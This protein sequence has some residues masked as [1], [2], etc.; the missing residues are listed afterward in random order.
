[1]GALIRHE[2]RDRLYREERKLLHLSHALHHGVK[3]GILMEKKKL[4]HAQLMLSHGVK[5][6]TRKNVQRIDFIESLLTA[7][8]P[9]Q[10]L[11]RG[12]TITSVEGHTITSA[13]ALKAGMD[14]Q[15]T[16]MDGTVKSKIL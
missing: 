2:I 5:N 8:D 11:A 13:H 3:S 12:Y 15:T 4:D 16:F 1:M 9:D 6:M 14:I 10:V 7:I